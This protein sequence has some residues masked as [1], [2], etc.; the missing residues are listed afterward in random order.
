MSSRRVSIRA[1]LTRAG[2]R[3]FLGLLEGL[4]LF[5][6]APRSRER[7]DKAYE[8]FAEAIDKFQSAP[9]S[10]ERGDFMLLDAARLEYCFN[11]RPAHASGAT[12]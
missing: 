8:D 1:P 3:A 2:R 9:R 4:F 11:P 5:Q 6:S 12:F 7:G 10:R